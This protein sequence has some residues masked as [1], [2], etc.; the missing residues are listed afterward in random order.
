MQLALHTGVHYTENEK[1]IKALLRNKSVLEKRGIAVPG[2]GTYRRLMRDALNA[3]ARAPAA[4]DARDL[5]LDAILDDTAPDRLI[6]SDAN[7]FRTAGTAVQK[8]VLY[9]AAPIRLGYLAQ[10]FDADDLEVFMAIRSPATLL[11][12][13]LENAMDPSH[14]GFWGGRAPIDLRWSE[15]IRQI[16]QAVPDVNITIW[17]AEDLPVI[18]SQVMCALSGIEA[19]T[20]L[21]GIHD[22]LETL[23]SKEGREKFHTFLAR[24]PEMTAHQQQRVTQ[25]FLEKFRVEAEVQGDIQIPGWSEALA[26]EMNEIYDEDLFAIQDIPGVRIIEP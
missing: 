16:R 10:V 9:P 18:W 4:P 23:L 14:E 21:V 7:F 12:I 20:A 1:L 2:P 5:L 15:T 24:Y 3:M 11:P 22:F 8:G 26:D 19:D 6:L 13:L 17:C 25:R